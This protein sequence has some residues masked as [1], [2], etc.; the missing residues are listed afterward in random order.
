MSHVVLFSGGM[1]SFIAAHKYPEATLLHVDFREKYEDKQRKVIEKIAPRTVE[2]LEGLDLSK[3]I[4]EDGVY[5]PGRNVLLIT[6]ASLYGNTIVLS[7]SAGAK[8]PDKDVVFARHMSDTLSY[9]K[10]TVSPKNESYTRYEVIRP[11]GAMT[12]YDIVT[13]YLQLG[14]DV[15]D[16]YSTSSCYHPTEIECMKC[17]SC[18]RRL[19]AFGLHGFRLDEVYIHAP[20]ISQLLRDNQWS[21][22]PVENEQ[23]MKLLNRLRP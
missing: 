9:A 8:H 10:N 12:K 18:L 20:R 17:R 4:A 6:L 14:G 15:R 11:F 13:E 16:L 19:V 22:N 23:A 7:S 5:L 3:F 1:D 2:I 21:A